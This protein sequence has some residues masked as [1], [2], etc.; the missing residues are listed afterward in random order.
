MQTALELAV[1]SQLHNHDLVN[2]EA[3]KVERL[4]AS[5]VSFVHGGRAWNRFAP[6]SICEM[7]VPLPHEV[8]LWCCVRSAG[9]LAR[10]RNG[11]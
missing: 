2:A 10:R 3:H 6:D 7:L 5:L 8:E 9:G 1:S 4:V 11:V